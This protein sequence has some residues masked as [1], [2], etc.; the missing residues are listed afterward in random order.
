MDMEMNKHHGPLP[1][2]V[3][4]V[5][6]DALANAVVKELRA[7]EILP[8]SVGESRA[9]IDPHG[10][11]SPTT[12]NNAKRARPGAAKVRRVRTDRSKSEGD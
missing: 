12:G 3:R 6:V 8:D 2:K 11:R 7:D 10:L 5:L 1:P 4:A 9:T